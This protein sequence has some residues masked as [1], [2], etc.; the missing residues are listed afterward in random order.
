MATEESEHLT[1]ASERIGGCTGGATQTGV[2][3]RLSLLMQKQR[4][5][6]PFESFFPPYSD[7]CSPISKIQLNW[8]FRLPLRRAVQAG[9]MFTRAAW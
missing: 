2:D 4:I 6:L 9:E 7:K 1:Q 8:R 3:R 5:H